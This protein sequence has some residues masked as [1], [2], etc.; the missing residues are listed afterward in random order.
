ME[1]S[2][3]VLLN[4]QLKAIQKELGDSDDGTDDNEDYSK[5]INSLK[6]TEEAKKLKM[7]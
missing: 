2:K 6:L 3:R 7:N 4:E 1:N 5:K